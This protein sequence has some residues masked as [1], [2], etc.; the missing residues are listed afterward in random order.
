MTPPAP[1][2]DSV[3]ACPPP[4]AAR[5]P[6]PYPGLRPF[7]LDESDIFFGRD[8]QIDS[9]LERLHGTRFLSVVGASGCGKS[10]LIGAG[11][12][13]AV[14]AGYLTG[15]A[16]GWR[17][18]MM[19]PRD[20]PLANLADGLVASG[21]PAHPGPDPDTAR[22]FLRVGLRRGPNSLL[23]ALP[24]YLG[25]DQNLLLIVD[26]FE[27]LFRFREH[28]NPDE[29]DAFA[30][31]LLASTRSA[32]VGVYIVL[33]MRS[34]FIGE[35]AVFAGLPEAVNDSQYLVPRLSRE[36]RAEAIEGPAQ[37]F[38]G[39]VDPALLTRLLNDLGPD[40]DNLPVL[41]HVLRRL[42]N[43]AAG[44]PGPPVLTLADYE[45][46]GGVTDALA[47]SGIGR[48]WPRYCSGRWPSGPR[49]AD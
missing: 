21:P 39:S 1:T 8:E 36:Q 3:V 47:D 19:Q 27:E 32:R 18:V 42:W 20:R 14:R 2:A 6:H 4:P 46:V 13:N 10:S 45:A 43:R 35:C 22:A 40:P 28:G 16:P 31:L 25:C 12:V 37:L 23:E 49:K 11:L 38:G 33:T 17:V 44:R 34:D 7:R 48:G 24:T 9:L 5:S 30:A 26:Q 15:P 29:A 41:Q